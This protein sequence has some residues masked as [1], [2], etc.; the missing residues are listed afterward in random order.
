M[1]PG[2]ACWPERRGW[3]GFLGSFRQRE[4]GGLE[5][6]WRAER[7]PAAGRSPAPQGRKSGSFR[8]GDGHL[9]RAR[10]VH[11]S[12][13]FA[14]VMGSFGKPL[15]WGRVTCGRMRTAGAD[16]GFVWSKGGARAL[17]R[18]VDDL[19]LDMSRSGVGVSAYGPPRIVP[20][21]FRIARGMAKKTCIS[22]LRK[23]RPRRGNQ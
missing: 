21:N 17:R 7:R 18:G 13:G 3:V 12:Y 4:R 6:R 23:R 10:Q 1:R 5:R 20:F 9:F 19:V 22:I 2:A 11:E 8:N 16:F 14:A 15:W